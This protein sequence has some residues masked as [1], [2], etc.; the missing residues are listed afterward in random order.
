MFSKNF[1]AYIYSSPAVWTSYGYFGTCGGRLFCADL[2]TGEL[3]WEFITEG[4]KADPDDMLN[5]NG[6][7]KAALI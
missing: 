7:I 4:A 6:T 2:K 5:D 3:L 1:L